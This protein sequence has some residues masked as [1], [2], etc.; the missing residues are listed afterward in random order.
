MGGRSVTCAASLPDGRAF[1]QLTLPPPRH[2]RPI[3]HANATAGLPIASST[4]LAHLQL[5]PSTKTHPHSPSQDRADPSYIPHSTYS[6]ELFTV[7]SKD[8]LSDHWPEEHERER[9]WVEG[10]E[11]LKAAVAWGE[12]GELMVAAADIARAKLAAP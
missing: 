8:V 5:V 4:H 10:W 6:F 1:I 2:P 12:R 7:A 11:A 9:Q 3:S